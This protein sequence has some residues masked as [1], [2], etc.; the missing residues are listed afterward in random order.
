[1]AAG[2]LHAGR[3]GAERMY[4]NAPSQRWILDSG[5]WRGRDGPLER[6]L[7]G[8][9]RNSIDAATSWFRMDLPS[10]GRVVTWRTKALRPIGRRAGLSGTDAQEMG[11]AATPCKPQRFKQAR[12]S[13]AGRDSQ[14][15]LRFAR[16]SA[17]GE[18]VFAQSLWIECDA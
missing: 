5:Y 13:Q 10:E 9:G 6:N 17:S 8:G 14:C 12:W 3:R 11:V 15:R 7:F 16:W 1:M 2:C 4:P 18:Q